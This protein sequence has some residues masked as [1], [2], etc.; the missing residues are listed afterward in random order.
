MTT[1]IEYAQMA[2]NVY[3]NSADV[4][5]NINTIMLPNGWIKLSI[6]P[7]GVLST[8]S[9]ATGFMANAYQNGSD[10]VVSYAGTTDENSLD[11]LT[12]N[13][14]AGTAA[15]HIPQILEAV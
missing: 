13:V 12:G 2:A 8:G 6:Q 3:G 4:R 1:K 5:S 9:T 10:I 15:T 14:P 11:W 7:A